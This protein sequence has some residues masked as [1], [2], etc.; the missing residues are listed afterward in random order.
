M[1]WREVLQAGLEERRKLLALREELERVN[2]RLLA[3]G[4]DHETEDWRV[5][6]QAVWEQ[7]QRTPWWAG[8]CGP[9]RPRAAGRERQ[10]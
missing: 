7:E 6:N 3:Q 10:G 1:G 9:T 4:I 2:E 5:A 8:G